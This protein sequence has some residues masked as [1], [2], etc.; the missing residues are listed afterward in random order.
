[1]VRLAAAGRKVACAFIALISLPH[2]AVVLRKD[3]AG[4]IQAL[5]Y[6]ARTK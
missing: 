2:S 3:A 6:S 1:M 5:A 4:K